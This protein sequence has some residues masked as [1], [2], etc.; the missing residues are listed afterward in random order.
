VR[1]VTT[2]FAPVAA[3]SGHISETAGVLTALAGLTQVRMYNDATPGGL[4][5]QGFLQFDTSAIP[6]DAIVTKVEVYLKI[7][8]IVIGDESTLGLA[9]DLGSFIGSSLD[10]VVAEWNGGTRVYE[11]TAFHDAAW[12]DL[13]SGGVNARRLVSRDG[14]TDLRLSDCGVT[15]DSVLMV[16]RGASC[17]LR[18]TYE[19]NTTADVVIDALVAKLNGYTGDGQALDGIEAVA[20]EPDIGAG[21]VPRIGVHVESF[22]PGIPT[23]IFADRIRWRGRYG[24][25]VRVEVPTLAPWW[26]TC[27]AYVAAVRS[28]VA[29]ECA[30][31]IDGVVTMR[32]AGGDPLRDGVGVLRFYADVAGQFEA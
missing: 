28:I 32:P 12:L 5:D 27:A 6:S 20:H 29:D 25:R 8:M 17:A 10:G 1:T 26:R 3:T 2:T 14:T 11:N 22:E 30:R 16:F 13:S 4:E 23:E 7:S 19:E 9:Y 18:V 15:L 24:V 21:V 31:A